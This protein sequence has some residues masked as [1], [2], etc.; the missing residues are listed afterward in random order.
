LEGVVGAG[1]VSDFAAGFESLLADGV[2]G[3][4]LEDPLESPEP[5]APPSLFGG[6]DPDERCAFLP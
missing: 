3:V 4:V 2:A 6:V 5:P 1:F